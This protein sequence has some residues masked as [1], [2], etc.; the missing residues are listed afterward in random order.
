MFFAVNRGIAHSNR[1]NSPVIFIYRL[2]SE[3]PNL[4]EIIDLEQKKLEV[5]SM[6]HRTFL[7]S[8]LTTRQNRSQNGPKLKYI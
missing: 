3:K 4:V 7:L 8:F 5:K 1:C 2:Q 6:S